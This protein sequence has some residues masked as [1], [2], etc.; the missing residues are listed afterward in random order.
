M[1]KPLLDFNDADMFVDCLEDQA[2]LLIDILINRCISIGSASTY[3]GELPVMTFRKIYTSAEIKPIPL[4]EVKKRG[5][6]L[7]VGDLEIKS[8]V[9]LRGVNPKDPW[10]GDGK[11]PNTVADTIFID[12]PH[13]GEWYVV[14]VPLDAQLMMGQDALFS[15]AAIRRKIRGSIGKDPAVDDEVPS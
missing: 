4:G 10:Y 12:A 14:G 1:S 11:N 6:V 15:S 8:S 2:P 9:L 5:G 7:V 3:P 13:Q